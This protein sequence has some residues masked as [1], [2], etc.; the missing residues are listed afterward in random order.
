MKEERFGILNSGSIKVFD[1]KTDE[2]LLDFSL[3]NK[4]EREK[5]IS[6]IHINN[7]WADFYLDKDEELHM[8]DDYHCDNILQELI[9]KGEVNKD[10]SIC[11]WKDTLE[12]MT[13]KQIKD[14]LIKRK[15]K[16]YQKEFA[17]SDDDITKFRT[18]DEVF[19]MLYEQYKD[20]EIEI[21]KKY[22]VS[23]WSWSPM[24]D[25][26]FP[27]EETIRYSYIDKDGSKV[28]IS[29]GNYRVYMPYDIC[30]T[31]EEAKKIC[32]IK[33]NYAYDSCKYEHHMTEEIENKVR[34]RV[35]L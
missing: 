6:D 7:Q 13:W 15:E 31:E 35:F 32:K 1:K 16:R 3:L 5:I 8:I 18:A 28:Y 33:G 2:V 4:E 23:E 21:G 26:Y 20:K 25:G 10:E 22:W 9:D 17:K 30:E 19:K 12:H 29:G 27:C 14:E 11:Y 24:C 34:R